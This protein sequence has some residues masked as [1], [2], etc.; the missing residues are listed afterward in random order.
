MVTS[1]AFLQKTHIFFVPL[2]TKT[3]LSNQ[4]KSKQDEKANSIGDGG[5]RY[6]D[7]RLV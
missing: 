5:Y 7:I 1:K 2:Q 6:R 4:R 3:Q